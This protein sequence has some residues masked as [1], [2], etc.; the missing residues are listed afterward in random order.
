MA[1]SSELLLGIDVGTQGVKGIL[2]EASG[3]IVAQSYVEHGSY[4]PQPD[5]CEQDM[6][7][8]WWVDPVEVIRGLL[9]T[10]G[11]IPERVKAIGIS[12]LYPALGPTDGE[13]NPIHG[14][15][16]Y[17]DNR[18]VAEVEEV[19]EKCGLQLSAEELTPKLIWFLRNKPELA[20][21]MRMFFDAHH[22]LVYKLCGEYVTD[23]VTTGLYGAIYE[24]PTAS[25]RADV[26]E[27]F[28]IPLEILPK[29]YPPAHI[30]GGVHKQASEI[31]GLAV[32]TPV[33]SG[34]PDLL[35]SLISVG[36]VHTHETAA[37]YGTA[38]LVP[39]MKD[40]LLNAVWKPYPI[41]ERGLTP[42]DG[43][44]FDYPAYCLTVADSTRWFRDEFAQVEMAAELAGNG[45]NAYAALSRLAEQTPTGA[46]GLLF[47]P[48]LLG[49][50]SPIFN[51]WATGVFFG[52][53]KIHTRGYLYRA[54]LE[55][56]G[57]MIRHGFETFYPQGHP[58]TRLVATGGGARSPIWRQVVSDITGLRQEYIPDADGP[59]A[60]AYVAGLAIG[61]FE[62]FE[63]LKNEWV[64]VQA[65]TEPNLA[66]KE[67]YDKYYSVYVNLHGALE[68]IYQEHHDIQTVPGGSI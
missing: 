63:I 31:T 53:K 52:L 4:Y 38:G 47:L 5:W 46:D 60:C 6:L 54:V 67:I 20:S 18:A 26:C 68:G 35:A 55:S 58:I 49:Q 64:K 42:Q 25:W 32:G 57:Y 12:G 37:N 15:I 34:M 48:Y 23:T 28:G 8:N 14:A 19:N 22:Y 2:V 65:V 40:D 51:P 36:T 44:V 17:S 3:D 9:E 39:V 21:Q 62:D 41:S 1:F 50:R 10:D 7:Q 16:L 61:W 45:P 59:V 13:G 27:M 29:A 66:V 11:V 30:V 56:F 43:Y 33:L 24:S